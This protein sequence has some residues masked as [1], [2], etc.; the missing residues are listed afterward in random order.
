MGN[1]AE[2]ARPDGVRPLTP[3]R[4]ERPPFV[5][6]HTPTNRR[7]IMFGDLSPVPTDPTVD[8]TPFACFNCW[9]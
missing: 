1:A 6:P 8:P 2:H 7:G 5:E 3:S 9:R 4:E